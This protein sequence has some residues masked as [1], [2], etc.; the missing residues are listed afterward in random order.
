MTF[1]CGVCGKV[2][3]SRDNLRQHENRHKN[4]GKYTC[5]TCGKASFSRA[6]AEMH[7]ASHKEEKP[8]SCV[9]CGKKF[10]SQ[11]Y[12]NR[13][14]QKEMGL[15]KKFTCGSCDQKFNK[16]S[17]LQDHL[18]THTQT[19]RHR[20]PKCE[21]LFRYSSGLSRHRTSKHTE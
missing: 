14:I 1:I 17:D 21:K 6:N 8:F 12:L 5:E 3:K 11:I 19:A 2:L 16:K 18:S 20:C 13:H 4:V 7:A 10:A 15:W 9:N